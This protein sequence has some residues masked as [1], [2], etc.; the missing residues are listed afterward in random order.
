MDARAP[1]QVPARRHR[2]TSERR[3]ARGDL[4]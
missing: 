2:N 4:S 3:L 1:V